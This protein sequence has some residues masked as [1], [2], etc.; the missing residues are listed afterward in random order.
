MA[1]DPD[2][3]LIAAAA[4]GD[5]QALDDLYQRHGLWLLTVLLHMLDDRAAAEEALQNVM[6]AVWQGAASF[7]GDSLVRTWLFAIA[8]RQASKLRRGLSRNPP[9]ELLDEEMVSR[10]ADD[11]SADALQSA[12]A[13]LPADQQQAL[14]LVYYR[15]LTVGEAAAY[16]N[17]PEGT[18]K[19]RLFRARAALRDLLTREADHARGC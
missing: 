8:R 7:R 15:G 13:R 9:T 17:V 4:A 2:A 18:V 6:L 10:R 11:D 19:S 16:L 3:P 14:E 5:K 12:L 1:D